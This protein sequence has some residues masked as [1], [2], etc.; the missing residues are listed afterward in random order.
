MEAEYVGFYLGSA[1]PTKGTTGLGVIQKPLREKYFAFRKSPDNKLGPEIGI[2]IN[3]RGILLMFPGARPGDPPNEEFYELPSVHFIEAVQLVTDKFKDKKLYGAFLPIDI[4]MDPAQEK[5]FVQIEKK[6]QHLAKIQHPPMLACIMRRSTGV[7][8]VDCHMFVI[9]V[10][11]DALQMVSMVHRFQ[12]R[13][14]DPDFYDRP[15]PQRMDRPEPD[16]IPRNM[17]PP[18]D[19]RQRDLNEEYELYRGR[20]LNLRQ[21]HFT[22]NGSRPTDLRFDE[23]NRSVDS[24]RGPPSS[25]GEYPRS[26]MDDPRDFRRPQGSPSPRYESREFPGE[27]GSRE[28]AKPNG[29]FV[30]RDS[31]GREHEFDNRIIHDRQRSGGGLSNDRFDMDRSGMRPRNEFADRSG[32]SSGRLDR[33]G[34]RSPEPMRG[35]PPSWQ[36]QRGPQR[37]SGRDYDEGPY[38]NQYRGDGRRSPPG[39]QRGR[40]P[41]RGY[42]PPR[43]H[44]S[45]RSPR[46][47]SP[48]P[49][50]NIYSASN[51][52]SR[53]EESHGKPVAKVQP[54]RHAGVRVL[55]SIPLAGAKNLLKPVPPKNTD[56]SS[57]TE[58][59]PPSYNFNAKA[60]NEDENPYDN[61]QD[62]RFFR[63]NRV[64][65]EKSPDVQRREYSNKPE[66]RGKSD[67]YSYA[68]DGGRRENGN[69]RNI[70]K[71]WSYEEE[72][73]KFLRN[74]D[75]DPPGW[76]SG[77]KSQSVHE[78]SQ[79]R[80]S[81]DDGFRKE[82]QHMKDLE[83]ADMF[84]NLRASNAGRD[85]DFESSLGYLP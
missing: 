76:N 34:E 85:V 37:N 63:Q 54:N 68:R 67:D 22:G 28:F 75:R 72:K 31:F 51:L 3:P 53:L 80:S 77:Y 5:L 66:S 39:M 8:A 82:G 47:M 36:G 29:A 10:V 19:P 14:V 18:I 41:P 46:A 60:N 70:P 13:P 45:P 43:G 79:D 62:K 48:G 16:V 58:E 26:P 30:E 15:P 21:E 38:P 81:S 74:R 73:E 11:Q 24:D 4:P 52:E 20:G 64:Q 84:S 25:R 42:S 57:K 23:P 1:A 27:R 55:P 50:D 9:P 78:I 49:D 69:M 32:E 65:S 83:I 6:F 35:P 17:G 61:A 7:R 71:P 56:S 33:S 2:R 44:S 12:E 40:S 59:K